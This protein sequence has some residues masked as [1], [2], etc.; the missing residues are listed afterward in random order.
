MTDIVKAAGIIIQDRKVLFVR[1]A[2]KN[3][4]MAPG[5]KPHVGETL[6]QTLVR[7]LDEELG[8]QVRPEDFE[9]FGDYVRPAAGQPGKTVHMHC[10]MVKQ[11]Q[12]EPR[13][14]Q[15]I[16]E[17]RWLTSE[18]PEDLEVASIFGHIILP[19]LQKRGLVD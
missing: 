3:I 6:E 19:E 9:P 2:G 7:E 4:L 1:A 16:E 13:P 14:S 15:E 8:L 10:F 11:W 18:L 12:G 5:G 17:M